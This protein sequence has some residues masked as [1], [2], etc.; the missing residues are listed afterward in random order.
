MPVI[1]DLR[2]VRSRVEYRARTGHEHR[3]QLDN[4]TLAAA[5][6]DQPVRLAANGSYNNVP[7]TFVA[8]LGNYSAQRDGAASF[9]LDLRVASGANTLDF[10]GTAT[11]L[12]NLDGIEGDVMLAAPRPEGLDVVD[13]KTTLGGPNNFAAHATRKGDIWRLDQAAGSLDG[14]P[15]NLPLLQFT[16]GHGGRPGAVTGELTSRRCRAWY[17]GGQVSL[18]VL[19]ISLNENMHVEL[20]GARL[21]D[22]SD[23]GDPAMGTLAS[24]SAE[25]DAPSLITGPVVVRHAELDGLSLLLKHT[26]QHG[27]DDTAHLTA[28]AVPLRPEAQPASTAD[29]GSI[30][31]IHD[32]RIVRSRVEYRASTG[33]EHRVQLDN[34]TL[35]AANLDQPVQPA[36]SGSY[37][38]VPLTFVA[39]LGSYSALR[40]AGAKFPL[41][42][43]AVSGAN[44]LDF[45]GTVT[46]CSMLLV[47]RGR[48]RWPCRRWPP[49][50]TSRAP[51]RSRTS[52]PV[53]A[54]T[55]QA[56]R[57]RLDEA[58]GALDGNRFHLPL[59]Q[60]VE[61]GAGRPDVLTGKLDVPRLATT[62]LGRLVSLESLGVS[63]GQEPAYRGARCAAGQ[64][65]GW[66]QF[67]HGDIGET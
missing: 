33:H 2:I 39:K 40:E 37:N 4:V 42:L 53:P 62:V 67:G 18:E 22:M 34:A 55:R 61:G 21:G 14:K 50:W 46:I 19:R 16:E 63:L 52:D 7:L 30:P 58:S 24:L 6:P 17:S 11:H 43:N 5:N 45:R 13:A 59:L 54:A 10:H 25:I 51:R 48:S 8:K 1:H 32:L 31:V 44:T 64:H 36:A 9:L 3:L 66:K 35:A 26:A 65:P 27:G 20:R 38:N 23:G 29:R 15:F 28:A 60:F 49:C 12:L 57:W 41:E 47:S 56:G